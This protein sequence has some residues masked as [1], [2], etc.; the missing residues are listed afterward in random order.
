MDRYDP[1]YTITDSMLER[2]A[3][4]S[5]K[6]GRI[7]TARGLENKPQLRRNNRIKSIHSS[8]RIEANSLSLGQV[9]DVIGGKM[10]IGAQRE[11]QEVKNAYEAY[12]R[13]PEIDPY[14]IDDLKTLHGIMTK[15]VVEESGFFRTGEEGVF[16]GDRC[17][18]VAPPAKLVNELMEN[19]FDWMNRARGSVHPL[20]LSAVFHYEF[21]FIHPF[22]DGN[23]RMARLMHLWYLVQQGYSSAL[24]VPLSEYVNKSRKGYYD[25]YTLAEEN[26]RISGVLDVTP[27]L[28]YFIENVYH[29]LN[30]AIPA[31]RT[32][33]AF[34]AAL[35]QGQVT[36][37]EKALWSFVLSAYGEAEFSTKQLEKDFG[38]AA[39]ATIRSFVLKFEHL[40][41]LTST[42]YGNRVKY[43]VQA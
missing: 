13:L 10:V 34:Q 35:S 11:I 12:E 42:R 4:I 40:G 33:K 43:R 23:G 2:V 22:A 19:L 20:I 14:S 26:A 28:V 5:E 18:F 6:L 29:K 17:V 41:L 7:S 24:F 36:E 3:S 31:R 27:F 8:L 32:T 15:C 39:Y 9:R 37:K 21:V 25:A 1:P 30:G 16:N 38:N